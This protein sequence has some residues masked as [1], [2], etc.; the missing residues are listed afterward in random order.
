MTPERWQQV[1]KIF[2]AALDRTPEERGRFGSEACA[3][4]EFLRRD[5]EKLH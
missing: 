3:D 1:E 4:D 5:V 2:Q